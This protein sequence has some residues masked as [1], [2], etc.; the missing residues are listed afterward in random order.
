MIGIVGALGLEVKNLC[1][2]LESPTERVFCGMK[3]V[4]GLLNGKEAVVASCGVGKVNAAMYTQL[5][6]DHYPVD[7]V[8]HTGIAGAVAPDISHLSLVVA[9]RLTA[10]DLRDDIKETCWPNLLWLTPD[11][12]LRDA[13]LRAAGS[14]GQLGTIV[15]GDQFVCA[16]A[17]KAALREHYDAS[18]TEMEGASVAQVCQVN[19]IPFAVIRCIS[20]LADDAASGDYEQFELAAA[21]KAANVVICAL[22]L[23]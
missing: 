4:S 18:C 23:L 1:D 12:R 6:L 11:A 16:S 20:D 5:L 19:G 2:R 14:D 21:E 7:M 22:A 10:H 8:I 13:L 9:D 15:T 3:Y 17:A